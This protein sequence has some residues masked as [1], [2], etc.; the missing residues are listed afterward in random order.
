M[1]KREKLYEGKAKILYATEEAG[2]LIQY[3]KD[4]ATANDGEKRGVIA[5]KG[6]VNNGV[7]SRLFEVLE[8]A[9]V[10]THYVR[11]LSPR[12]ML[13]RQV[14]IVPVEVVVRNRV[15]GSLA[16]RLGLSEGRELPWPVVEFYYKS[17]ELHDPLVV[18]DH[19]LAFG[20]AGR[21]ELAEMRRLALRCN[22]VLQRFFA[23]RG[24]ELVDFKLEFGRLRRAEDSGTAIVVADEIT[25]DSCRLWDMST[26]EKLDKDRFRRDLGGVE[27][28][29]QEVYQR[30]VGGGFA[31]GGADA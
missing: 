8:G 15:A 16:R 7:S 21:E 14:E 11:C 3:F 30:V 17:D 24:I 9:G 19:I 20:W 25:P 31:R 6:V 29:Y 1:E 26:Q 22:E 28:A 12:E 18:E 13:V 2:L 5:D 23:E 4:E 10:A 27:D